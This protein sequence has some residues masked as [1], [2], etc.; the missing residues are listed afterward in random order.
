MH[1]KYRRQE[2]QALVEFAFVLPIMLALVFGIVE[3][4]LALNKQGDATHIAS[5]VARFA[6]VNENP[7]KREG[8]TLAQWGIEQFHNEALQ[9]GKKSRLCISFPNV[10]EAGQGNEAGRP[11]KVAITSTVI[12]LPIPKLEASTNLVGS[13]VMRLETPAT[14]YSAECYES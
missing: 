10:N 1:T 3:F 14:Y 7:G 2:G 5:E 4:A 11:V 6:A 9:N 12:W 13:A 8:K